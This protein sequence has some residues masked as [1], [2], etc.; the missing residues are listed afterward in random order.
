MN[1]VTQEQGAVTGYLNWILRLE[2]L[3]VFVSALILYHQVIGQS[4]TLFF[5]L[6]FFP[7]IGFLGYLGG[8]KIGALSYNA[9]HTYVAPLALGI[10]CWLLSFSDWYFL[11]VIWVAHIG[12]DR[13]VG[14]GLKYADGF[15]FTHLGQLNFGE[16]GKNEPLD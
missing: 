8:K 11:V 4:W 14:F 15:K 2:G 1:D 3:A 6:F 10:L 7:D 5:L 13:S 16:M 9:L 12:F